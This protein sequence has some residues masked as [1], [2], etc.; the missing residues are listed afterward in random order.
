MPFLP[1]SKRP[2]GEY[3]TSELNQRRR[4]LEHAVKALAG[5][6]IRAE[7]AKLL[8]PSGVTTGSMTVHCM[9]QLVMSHAVARPDD[10]KLNSTTECGLPVRFEAEPRPWEQTNM[11]K[12]CQQCVDTVGGALING[13]TGERWKP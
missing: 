6:P 8:V 9:P 12:R 10:G 3:T 4:E 2:L 13:V 1:P 7:L 11:M 5:A